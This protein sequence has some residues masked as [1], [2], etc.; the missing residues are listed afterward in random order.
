MKFWDYKN[1]D[2]DKIG[3][4]SQIAGVRRYEFAEGKAK[5][6]EALEIHTGA[7]LEFTVLPG[8]AMDIAWTE[9]RGIPLNY[10]AKSGVVAPEYYEAEGMGWLNN[11]FAGTLTTCGL[12]NVG[13][14]EN[15]THSVIGERTYGLHGRITNAA[16]EQVSV[17]EE[18]ENG[19]YVMKVSGLVSEGC[20]HCEH[21][22]LRREITTKLGSK[23]FTL[24]DTITNRAAAEQDVMLL[25]HIN[26]GYPLLDADSKLYS[27][28]LNIEPQSDE[29]AAEMDIVDSYREPLLGIAE[30]CYAHD[31][32]TDENGVV[33][34]AFVN[35]KLELGV[36]LEYKKEQLPFFNHWKM[37]NKKEYVVGLEPGNC[38]PR[39]YAKSKQDGMLD[40]IP[41]Y[42]S[43]CYEVTYKILDG[44]EEIAA[45]KKE[46]EKLG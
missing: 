13:G 43:K 29:A 4:I 8:R 6:V 28:S 34:L 27:K 41:P 14:F 45:Y 39:G 7:G 22:T 42:E 35:E 16:A 38:L 19:E 37:M 3:N 23:E 10:M 40:T 36:A 9:Y 46:I 15:V 20:L 26:M 11:F 33:K 21:L 30:R 44:A 12:L 25:Y 17:Y 18:W 5:G 1:L 32:A 31:F 2:K 24:K